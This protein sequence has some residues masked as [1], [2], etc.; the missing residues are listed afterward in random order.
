[1][2]RLRKEVA[3][4]STKKLMRRLDY[5]DRSLAEKKLEVLIDKVLYLHMLCESRCSIVLEACDIH[6]RY[7]DE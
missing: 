1:M 2:K 3:T 6:D 5:G 4:L 7:E